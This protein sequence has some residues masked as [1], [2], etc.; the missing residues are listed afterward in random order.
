MDKSTYGEVIH[1]Y[2]RAQAIEDGVLIDVS[3]TAAEAGFKFP[4]A[5]T[6]AVYE[7]YVEWTEKDTKQH[8]TYQ[9]ESGRLWDVLFMLHVAISTGSNRADNPK[10][11]RG[12]TYV[13][14]TILYRF[15]CVPR[16]PSK[17]SEPLEFV[18]KAHVGPGDNLE[19]VITIMLPEED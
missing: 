18:L 2:T 4:V 12:I 11:E 16:G 5:V 19:P 8:E 9:D 17:V 3:E 14:E 6:Q 10:V 7:K 13:G 1:S 15:L